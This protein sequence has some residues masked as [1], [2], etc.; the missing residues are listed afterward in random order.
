MA[1]LTSR[2]CIEPSSTDTI[3][4]NA[5]TA[6]AKSLKI[7]AYELGKHTKLRFGGAA[8]HTVTAGTDTQRIRVYLG[9]AKD[10]T[11]ILLADTTAVDGANN[12][13]AAF[14]GELEVKTPGA[15]STAVVEGIG[16][17]AA[18]AGGTAV[19]TT[20]GAAS[21]KLDT[22]ADMYLTVTAVHSAASGNT[23][24]LDSLWCE[25]SKLEAASS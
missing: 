2:R 9:T 4:S 24:R 13:V 20:F 11:G 18:K 1:S 8:V 3:T 21:S 17:A 5:E 15:A 6:F 16:I 19:P 23:S 22:T 7:P 14:N 12:D 25:V 10:A